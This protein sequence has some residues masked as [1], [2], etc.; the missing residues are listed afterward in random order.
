MPKSPPSADDG[1][2]DFSTELFFSIQP[3]GDVADVAAGAKVLGELNGSW[4]LFCETTIAIA[5]MMAAAPPAMISVPVP[6]LS[7]A[8][9]TPAGLPGAKD[10]SAAKAEEPIIVATVI[11]ATTPLKRNIGFPPFSEWLDTC[12]KPTAKSTGLSRLLLTVAERLY[13]IAAHFF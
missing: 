9:S 4:P 12:P 1:L 3:Q 6:I 10:M 5:V 2:S 8:L 13:R 7:W 11:A